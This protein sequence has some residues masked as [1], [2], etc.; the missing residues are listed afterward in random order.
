[1]IIN[2]FFELITIKKLIKLKK[3]LRPFAFYIILF[4]TDPA[5]LK[6]LPQRQIEWIIDGLLADAS[7]L[8][9]WHEFPLLCQ[10]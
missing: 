6:L 8:F 9:I 10:K 2:K 3:T 7:A 5:S 1:M 4:G